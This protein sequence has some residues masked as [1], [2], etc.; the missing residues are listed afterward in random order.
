MS[1]YRPLFD[2]LEK[3][4]DVIVTLPFD[5]IDEILDDELPNSAYTYPAWWANSMSNGHTQSEAWLDA[6]YEVVDVKLGKYVIFKKADVE[7]VV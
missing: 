7:Y 1:K 4:G 2:Y 5:R 3:C 6:G